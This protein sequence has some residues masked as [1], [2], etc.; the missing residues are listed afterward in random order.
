MKITNSFPVTQA[1]K[2]NR[3]EAFT[4]L[5]ISFGFFPC[6]LGNFLHRNCLGISLIE[7]TLALGVF[8]FAILPI[9][10][11]VSVGMGSLRGSMDDTVRAV[12]VS[13]VIGEAQRTEW[14]D[15]DA[16]FEGQTF[17]YTDEGVRLESNTGNN[18]AKTVFLANTR[19]SDSPTLL[20]GNQSSRLLQV[21]IRHFGDADN[22]LAQSQLVVRSDTRQP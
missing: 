19:L 20:Q 5:G 18:A 8:T 2:G 15:L 16:R 11:L 6:R 3:T 4:Q 22:N 10:G 9:M 17:Y 13:E 14:S 21:T 7:V 12:I 1:Q